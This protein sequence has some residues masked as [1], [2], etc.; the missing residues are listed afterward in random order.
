MSQVPPVNLENCSIAAT[1]KLVG[2]KWTLLVLRDVFSG[3]R[4]F[5]EFQARLHCS[6]AVLSDRLKALVNA[7]LLRR[8]PY[9][10]P[11]DRE[12]FE[13]RPTRAAVD[14]LPVL[15]GLMQWGDTHLTETGTGPAEVRS[16]V[17]GLKVRAALVDEDGNLTA[18]GDM[19]I[20]PVSRTD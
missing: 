11:G 18:P 4:R 2:E 3:V 8:V 6:T 17:T 10:E 12:R 20:R 16:T 9:Q 15:I 13:Y 14:L 7:G 5:D 19:A 1:L